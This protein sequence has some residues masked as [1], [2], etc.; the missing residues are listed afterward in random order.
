MNCPCGVVQCDFYERVRL[1][2]RPDMR[3]GV[4]GR[5][6]ETFGD[7]SV[8]P[9]PCTTSTF[10]RLPRLDESERHRRAADEHPP[11]TRE[12][13]VGESWVLSEHQVRRG[14]AHHRRDATAFD[15]VDTRSGSN[16]RF[17][18]DRCPLPPGEKGCTFQ[19]PT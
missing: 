17:E 12:I 10:A 7:A 4:L 11:K 19:P 9:Y 8:S 18:H 5:K 15:E 2:H 13:G 1:A 6:T 3:S 16:E 14:H